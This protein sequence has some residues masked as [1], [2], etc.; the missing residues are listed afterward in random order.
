MASIALGVTVFTRTEKLAQ[1]LSSVEDPIEKVYVAD[2]GTIDEEREQVYAASYPF[3]LEVIDLAYGSGLGHG[4]NEIVKH[5][6]EDYLVIVDS[7]NEVPHNIGLLADQL[8][9]RPGLGGVSGLLF[10]FG[11]VVGACHDFYEEDNVLIKDIREQKESQQ[12]A[13]A[14]FVEFEFVPNAGMFRKECLDEYSW[15]PEYV[16][17]KEHEDFFIGHKKQTDWRFGTCPSV[18]FPHHPG[19]GD[20]YMSNRKSN[21]ELAKSKQYFLQKWNYRQ[22]VYVRG[23]WV[24]SFT[25][26]SLRNWNYLLGYGARM[27]IGELPPKWK[28][29]AMDLK[30]TLRYRL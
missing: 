17:G 14:P 28:A 22:L 27:A 18:V 20:S 26:P 9:A 7:D 19:G 29:V 6:S 10:E 3:E 21:R 12:I 5:L 30:D 13:G 8:D 4:R 1:L 16:I 11:N 15:D 24:E 2:G 25:D 23:R